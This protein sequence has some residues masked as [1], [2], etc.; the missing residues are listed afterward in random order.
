MLGFSGNR[1]WVY[2]QHITGRF[3]R[4]RRWTFL[5]LH[6]VLF[7]TPWVYV[8]GNPALRLDLPARR[9]YALGAVFT[10]SDTVLLL[11][12]ALFL[13]FSLFF[14]TSLFGRLWC[15]YGCPQ[16]VLLDTWIRPIERW[17]EGEWTTRQRRDRMGVT[18]ALV[19]RKAAKW[20]LF[21]AAALVVSA[22]FMS[23]FAGARELWS[24]RAG[25]V[26]YA[27]VGIFAAGWFLD[28]A[29][30]R[31]QLCNFLCPYARFQSALTDDDT[32]VIGYDAR[33]GEPRGGKEARQTGACI[34]CM[35]CV[36]VCPQGI[37]IR[38]G[39]QLECIGC[40]RCID[41]CA[42]VMGKFG[43]ESL[44]AYGSLAEIAKGQARP[45][46][47]RPR[48]VAYAGL[49]AGIAAAAVFLLAT[50]VP[51]E[52]SLVRAPGSLA[53][54]DPDGYVRNTYLLRIANNAPEGG[55][56]RFRVRVDGVPGAQVVAP[57]LTLK[58]EE[59]Q[60]APLVVRIPA[61][62]SRFPRTIP[63]V[64][65]VAGPM[66]ERVL[67]TTFRTGETGVGATVGP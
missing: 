3:Q 31:E 13:A 61:A 15:G 45:R 39:F 21:A 24:G 22:A 12:V 20:A 52:A 19:W 51:F 10:A 4:L 44:V 53:T 16:T 59:G 57:E 66:G 1:K 35:K 62:A 26:S 54:L 55:T 50:R 9:L 8:R 64:V 17:I 49:L 30:F 60:L 43:H 28:F 2:V 56:A 36:N 23:F 33:R 5:A 48:T 42:S 63:L 38:N 65:R 18:W 41:A 34:D 6:V 32:L 47:L 7:V 29:W 40:A 37:D 25:A 46:L 58:P 14:F 67:E 11:L 27:L